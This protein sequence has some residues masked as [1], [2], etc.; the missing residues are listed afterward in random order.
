MITF[1]NVSFSLLSWG[2]TIQ[3]LEFFKIQN[4]KNYDAPR[5]RPT[6]SRCTKLGPFMVVLT[7]LMLHK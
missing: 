7:Y 3:R 2:I 1:R 6:Q 5:N 4:I